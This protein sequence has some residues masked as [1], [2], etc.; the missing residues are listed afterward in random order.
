LPTSLLP[1][2]RLHTK[3]IAYNP[4]AYMDFCTQ[5]KISEIELLLPI[6]LLPTGRLLTYIIAYSSQSYTRNGGHLTPKNVGGW[7]G[8]DIFGKIFQADTLSTLTPPLF[9]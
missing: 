5:I 8:L 9:T 4:I 1:T 6:L 2:V 7:L 3:I